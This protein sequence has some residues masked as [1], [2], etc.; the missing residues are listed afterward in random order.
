ME[1]IISLEQFVKEIS[2]VDNETIITLYLFY[3]DSQEQITGNIL[4][5]FKKREI[6]FYTGNNDQTIKFYM[7]AEKDGFGNFDVCQCV[8]TEDEDVH[9][10]FTD[11]NGLT[12]LSIEV[13]I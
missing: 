4:Y 8:K 12:I 9:Y 11:K 6:E 7:F 3:Y 2:V 13:D 1:K 5:S 10:D